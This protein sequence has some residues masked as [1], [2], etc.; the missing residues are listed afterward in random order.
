LL[1]NTCLT[2]SILACW[3]LFWRRFADI[4][5]A[6][7]YLLSVKLSKLKLQTNDRLHSDNSAAVLHPQTALLPPLLRCNHIAKPLQ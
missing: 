6:R 4:M 3:L 7:L 1:Y 2:K 5:C